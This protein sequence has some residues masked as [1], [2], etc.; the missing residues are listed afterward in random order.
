MYKEFKGKRKT[1]NDGSNKKPSMGQSPAVKTVSSMP[2]KGG[3][4]KGPGKK[5]S[6]GMG[7]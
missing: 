6:K 4:N 7:C 2:P 3:A 1:G 5:T